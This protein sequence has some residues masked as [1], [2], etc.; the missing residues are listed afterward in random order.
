MNADKPILNNLERNHMLIFIR[1]RLLLLTLV[2]LGL[3][4]S[5]CILLL[6]L[7]FAHTTGPAS[8]P[9]NWGEIV[10]VASVV[11]LATS[12]GWWLMARAA[13]W[14]WRMNEGISWK[15][16]MCSGALGFVASALLHDAVL[17]IVVRRLYLGSDALRPAL[18]AGFGAYEQE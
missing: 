10:R 11:V 14:L 3:T 5:L 2:C 9:I 1:K 12:F 8:S 16:M 4:G 17:L 13:G 15:F 18:L 6:V 7:V